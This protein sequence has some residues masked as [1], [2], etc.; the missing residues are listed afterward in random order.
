MNTRDTLALGAIQL[1]YTASLAPSWRKFVHAAS[2][3]EL[4]QFEKLTHFLGQNANTAYGRKYGYDQIH[5]VRSFQDR[6][7]IVDYDDLEPYVL[8]AARGEQRVLSADPIK[9]FEC[10]SGSSSAT[11]LIPYTEG[12]L[13]EF[14]AATNAW[15]YNI[16][17]QNLNLMGTQ[18]YWSVSPSSRER[19]CTEGGIPVGFEDDTEYFSPIGRWALR[20]MMAVPGTVARIHD[21]DEWRRT[22]ALHLLK[23]ER[24]GFI[25]IWSPTFLSLMMS[26]IETDFTSLAEDL[27]PTRTNAIRSSLDAHGAFVGE[28]IWP[29]LGLISCWTDGYA[30][31]YVPGLKRWFPR[32]P[33]QS[34]GL[35][36]TE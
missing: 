16:F 36:A 19:G 27:P 8:R 11:K 17:S 7:P 22:T 28:A 12:L 15:L 18:S 21:M 6:V 29:K 1:G 30:K 10:S 9:M 31:T 4:T 23:S 34:K 24:L 25:S 26:Y 14:S 20:K 35:L 5:D 2:S 13:G 32:T 33:I 3:L